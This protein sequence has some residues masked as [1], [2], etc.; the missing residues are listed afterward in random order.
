MAPP[1]LVSDECSSMS[2]CL[3]SSD[4]SNE[5]SSSGFAK[6]ELIG[7]VTVAKSLAVSARKDSQAWFF[8]WLR[9]GVQ[10]DEKLLAKLEVIVERTS[11]AKLDALSPD[12]S[13]EMLQMREKLASMDVERRQAMATAWLSVQAEE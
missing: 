9:A 2:E 4:I 12:R 3:S 7:D 13:T 11:R 6:N 10:H 8:G 1:R 5:C